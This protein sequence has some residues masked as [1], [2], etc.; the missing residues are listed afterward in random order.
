LEL[1]YFAILK[2]TEPISLRRPGDE[3][4]VDLVVLNTYESEPQAGVTVIGMGDM[5]GGPGDPYEVPTVLLQT[6]LQPWALVLAKKTGKPVVL[7]L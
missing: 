7:F 1:K 3:T 5:I 4:G 2:L 6:N